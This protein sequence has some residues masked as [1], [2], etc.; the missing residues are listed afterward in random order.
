[1][2]VEALRAGQALHWVTMW[3]FDHLHWVK[4]PGASVSGYTLG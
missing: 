4:I 1:M 3:S 2:G